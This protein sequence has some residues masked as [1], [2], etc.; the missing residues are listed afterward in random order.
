MDR[1][2]C[3]GGGEP[4]ES[5]FSL[6]NIPPRNCNEMFLLDGFFS[7][8]CFVDSVVSDVVDASVTSGHLE[9]S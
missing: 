3:C 5:V 7:V 8:P 4:L 2:G 9:L 1:R 6:L